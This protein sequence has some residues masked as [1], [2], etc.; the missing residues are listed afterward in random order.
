[1]T[2]PQTRRQ[3]TLFI[4]GDHLGMIEE[5]R[6]EFNAVQY[7]LISAHVTLCREDETSS[8]DRV[9]ENI[10]RMAFDQPLIIKFGAVERFE[11]GKGV[12]LPASTDN[13]QFQEWRKQVLKGVV[14]PPAQH[15][16]HVTLMHPRNSTCT[17]DTFYKIKQYPLPTELWFNEI[18]LIEQRNGGRWTI[19][20][21][22]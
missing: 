16:P 1:M 13:Q 10:E 22:F 11:N 9:L 21:K 18:S 6:R 19:L 4:Q 17:D 3:L 2:I 7:G 14:D 5:I 8:M 12:W 20:D 15:S